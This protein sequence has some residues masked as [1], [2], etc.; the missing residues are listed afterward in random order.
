VAGFAYRNDS[1]YRHAVAALASPQCM[2]CLNPRCQEEGCPLGN[3]IPEWVELAYQG[4]WHLASEALHATNNFPEFTA[5]ICQAP[6]QVACKQALSGF[7]VQVAELERQIVEWAFASGWVIPQSPSRKTGRKVAVI[8]S[9]PGGLAAAQQL[10]RAGHEV[11]VFEKDAACGGLLRYGIPAHR[12]DKD[13]IDRRLEQLTG[14][15]IAF[16]TGVEAGRDV[17]VERL[18]EE[19]DA[20]CLAVGASRARDLNI[21]GRRQQG[22]HFAMDFLR[23]TNQRTSGCYVA[24]P[25]AISAKGKVVAVLGAGLTGQDC[26]EAALMQGARMVHQFEILPPS[27]PPSRGTHLLTE[28]PVD[29][30]WCVVTKQFGGDG[31][32]LNEIRGAKVRWLHSE[33]GPVMRELPGSD[34]RVKVDLALLAMGFESVPDGDLARRLGLAVDAQGRIVA[35]GCATSAPDVFVAGDLATGPAYVATAIASGRQAADRINQFLQG[36]HDGKS[37]CSSPTS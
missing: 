27:A 37:R 32:R 26:V 4:L 23:Q 11:V 21:P 12:L 14:E 5:R 15:G 16:R 33:Q 22:V 30:Q 24:E 20:I 19:F 28:G 18:R 35:N 25:G 36:G 6:C 3:R 13:L 31:D 8:G 34:F 1:E 2:Q 7:P 9:G 29:R 17:P 10:A